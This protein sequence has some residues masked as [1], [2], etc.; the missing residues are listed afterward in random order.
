MLDHLRKCF[1]AFPDPREGGNGQ[2]L[3][4]DFGMAAFSVFFMQSP[5][6]LAHQERLERQSGRSNCQTL[7]G[8]GKIPKESQIRRMLD[9][10]P[11]Q[12]LFP[13]FSAIRQSLQDHPAALKP[14]LRL[15][16]RLLI[17][18]DGAE[19]FCSDKKCCGAG[20]T[21]K[22]S[23]GK[24]EYFHSMV[25]ATIVAPGHN[26]VIPLAPEFMTPQ[27]GAKKQDS[28]AMAAKRWLAAHGQEYAAFRPIYLGD[29][30][31]SHQPLCRAIQA[32]GGN[33]IFTCKPSSHQL[34]AEYIYGVELPKREITFKQGRKRTVHRYRWLCDLPLRDGKDA[35]TV[36][37]FEIEILDASGEVTYRNSF[38]TDL[39]VNADTVAE[40][41]ECGRA[42]WK[43]E[44]E[45]INVLKNKGYNLEHNYGHGKQ[46]LSSVLV[47]LNLIAFALHTLC[48]AVVELWASA[49]QKHRSRAKFFGD[50]GAITLYATFPTWE[51][52]LET[53]AF[54]RQPPLPP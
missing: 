12:L 29:D 10:V 38:V 24:T 39:L 46:N 17:A 36:N 49:R 47:S 27:D 48:D 40:L 25:M 1:E 6:F 41:T 54:K 42:R 8:M 23:N 52:L 45:T 7:F 22:R 44:N 2:Y 51:D 11:P 26:K 21:R 53:L 15:G 19:Y 18:L 14:F 32:A 9:P 3:M 31:F 43:I 16:D 35:M 33:F 4:S 28:E 20:S 13:M 34:I 50:M 5:S 37:W 30:L